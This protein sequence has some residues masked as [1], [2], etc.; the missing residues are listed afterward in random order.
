MRISFVRLDATKDARRLGVAL[1]PG[2]QATKNETRLV[3]G[4]RPQR[5]R[6][7]P[8]ALRLLGLPQSAILRSFSWP[9][10]SDAFPSMETAPVHR[11]LGRRGRGVAAG[12]A[13]A[14]G[15]ADAAH[16]HTALLGAP[17][18]LLFGPRTARPRCGIRC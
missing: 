11:A 2:E 15:R 18:M 9:G 4:L 8:M 5:A 16:R 12:G 14:A 13:S 17:A 7:H 1:L 10:G 6:D 3:N